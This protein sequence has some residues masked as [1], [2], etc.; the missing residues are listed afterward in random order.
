MRSRRGFTLVELLVV[1][2][3]I[4]LLVALMLPAVQA[5]REAARANGCKNSLKQIGLAT[6]LFQDA[7]EAFPPARLMGTY[8]EPACG[9]PGPAWPS[10]LVRIMP[11][12]E[13][14]NGQELWRLDMS[15]YS[16]DEQ[17][18]AVLPLSYLC[19]SRRGPEGANI[20]PGESMQLVTYPCGCVGGLMIDVAAGVAG[21]YAA[22]HGDTSPPFRGD[23]DDAWFY[24]GGGTGV[25]ISSRPKCQKGLPTTW[26]DRI[27]YE[28]I[29]DGASKTV[30]AGEKYVPPH[31]M[32]QGPHDG[33]M[34]NGSD[35]SALA[36]FA[37][38]VVAP[39]A[40]SPFDPAIPPTLAMS[41]GSWHP[42]Y[43]PFVWVDGSVRTV[44]VLIDDEAYVSLVN[45]SDAGEVPKS[46]IGGP[47]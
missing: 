28:D 30:L 27:G 8:T 37:D 10:W 29:T 47:L 19:P 7:H 11:Y 45:R 41:F 14:S 20:T 2:A 6:I 25:I 9:N 33:P 46:S 42:G 31:G 15:Y 26:I 39:L 13:E 43:C 5:A 12:L 23:D 22:N 36:R 3:I 4:G 38:P 1:I 35:L 24:G 17:A 18:L 21:D 34:Y 44:D 32:R 40:R 16:Q